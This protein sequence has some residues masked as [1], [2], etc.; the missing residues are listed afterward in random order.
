MMAGLGPSVFGL[1]P[2][3]VGGV[4]LTE[5]LITLI[6]VGVAFAVLLVGVMLMIWFERKL[7]SDMQNRIGP[8]LA[9]PFGIF[10]TLADGIKLFFKEDLIPEQSD[11]LV[12]KLAPYL[13]LVP[14]FLVFAVVPIGGDFSGGDG[15]VTLFGH[16]TFLQVSDPPVGILLVLAMSSVA[17]YGVMLAGW[18][19]GSKYPLLASVRASAQMVSYEAA[20][21]LSLAAVLLKSGSLS[22]NQIVVEQSVWNWNLWVTWV[23]PM[24]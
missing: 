12:F 18:S 11:R 4:G 10:Q 14:A 3:Y 15:R 21:G 7:I 6:K 24:V 17:V 8:N 16:E 22:T 13:S 9:G 5:V 2:L 1:D 23:V 19:S 20:L